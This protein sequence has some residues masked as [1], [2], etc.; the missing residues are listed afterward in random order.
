MLSFLV[1]VTIESFLVLGIMNKAAINI[2]L[3]DFLWSCVFILL[4]YVTR[5]VMY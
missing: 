2:H 1:L 5:K 3:Y 4:G